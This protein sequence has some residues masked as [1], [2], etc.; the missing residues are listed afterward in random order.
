[1][2]TTDYF[3][4]QY[5]SVKDDTR[6]K[7]KFGTM[8]HIN[9]A[10]KYLCGA[11]TREGF[12][13]NGVDTSELVRATLDGLVKYEPSIGA[14][15]QAGYSITQAGIVSVYKAIKRPPVGK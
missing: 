6:I 10:M 12:L 13:Q 7:A 14:R 9:I 3:T 2:T 15:K 4:K 5:L 8:R 11:N 1:M